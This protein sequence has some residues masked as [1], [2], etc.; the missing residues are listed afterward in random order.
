MT[1]DRPTAAE[2]LT[3]ARATLVDELMPLLPE[4]RR[5]DALLVATAMRIA[6]A[7]LAA[8][9]DWQRQAAD[10]LATLYGEDPGAVDA[11]ALA[12]LYRRFA[13][14]IRAGAFD[15]SDARATV[16]RAILRAIAEH[17]LAENNP[18][19]PRSPPPAAE[20]E[21]EGTR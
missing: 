15:A 8:G 3:A 18:K 1:R 19:Y 17:K 4:A 16:A 20:E 11:A 10:D 9:D 2:L 12:R 21:G 6:S 7:E 5:Y 14:D 13:A